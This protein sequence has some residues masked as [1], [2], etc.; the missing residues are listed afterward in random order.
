MAQAWQPCGRRVARPA[1]GLSGR[2][3][4]LEAGPLQPGWGRLPPHMPASRRPPIRRRAAGPSI[5]FG[6]AIRVPP[7]GNVF[8]VEQ[9]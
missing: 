5:P 7:R 4:A 8:F 3:R 9:P 2:A 6:A 1:R